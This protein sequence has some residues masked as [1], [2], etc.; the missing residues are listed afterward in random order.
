VGPSNKKQ[1]RKHATQLGPGAVVYAL[2]FETGHIDMEGVK[3]FREKEIREKEIRQSL[4]MQVVPG[5]EL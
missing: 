5:A 4:T 2:G 1:F 3:V